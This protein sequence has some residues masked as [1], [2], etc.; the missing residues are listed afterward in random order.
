[1]SD[2]G[3]PPQSIRAPLSRAA[4]RPEAQP[5]GWWGMVLFLGSEATI[6]GSLIGTYFYLDFR[7]R[8]WPPPG[9]PLPKITAAAAA[10][11][12]LL[13][14]APMMWMAVRAIYRR[15]RVP[16]MRWIAFGLA[17]QAAYLGVQIV[18]FRNDLLQVS[19]QDSAYGSIYFTLL[20]ADHAHVLVGLLISLMILWKLWRAGLTSYWFIGVR[21]LALYWY[22][23]IA[24]T[25][26]VLV[27]TLSP[28][29]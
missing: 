12:G 21:G 6:F 1:M 5:H 11:G 18:L 10:T 2:A 24:L 8:H 19:P 27:T 13:L 17:V 9:V 29:F 4:D 20:A 16:A 28:S 26:L 14:T 22:V 15:R 3:Q 23:V 7:V 25:I